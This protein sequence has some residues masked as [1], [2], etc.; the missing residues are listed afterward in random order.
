MEDCGDSE[1]MCDRQVTMASTMVWYST[2]SL[3][4]HPLGITRCFGIL[5][6]AKKEAVKPEPDRL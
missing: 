4:L 6:A 3:R 2:L 1:K 5:L